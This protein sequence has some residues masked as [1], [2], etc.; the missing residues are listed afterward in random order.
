MRYQD[1][2]IFSCEAE[3]GNYSKLECSRCFGVYRSSKNDQ[4]Y[5]EMDNAVSKDHWTR[6]IVL[7][8]TPRIRDGCDFLNG[9]K[10]KR[11]KN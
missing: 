8:W 3:T 6:C 4:V 7:A 5:V 10:K 2:K 9:V 11:E 1:T